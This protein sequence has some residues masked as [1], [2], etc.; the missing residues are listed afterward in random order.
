MGEGSGLQRERAAEKRQQSGEWRVERGERKEI[1]IS[2]VTI[3][4]M[5]MEER[6]RE[7]RAESREK[8]RQGGEE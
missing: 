1:F 2:Q 4:A 8:G 6:E 7:Q 3:A 5:V